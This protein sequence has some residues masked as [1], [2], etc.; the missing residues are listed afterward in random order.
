MFTIT[1]DPGNVQWLHFCVCCSLTFFVPSHFF[2]FLQSL[3]PHALCFTPLSM[4]HKLYLLLFYQHTLILAYLLC[5]S[6]TIPTCLEDSVF[7]LL[8]SYLD[9]HLYSTQFL[10]PYLPD[11]PTFLP[12]SLKPHSTQP[13]FSFFSNVTPFPPVTLPFNP[14]LAGTTNDAL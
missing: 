3:F 7:H 14:P 1:F 8:P 4:L 6:A 2:P 9:L 12:T 11:P 13:Y 5:P 10:P